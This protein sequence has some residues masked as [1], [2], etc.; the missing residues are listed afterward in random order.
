MSSSTHQILCGAC[1]RPVKTIANAK[2]NHEVTCTGCGRKDRLDKVVATAIPTLRA[3]IAELEQRLE[4]DPAQP[5]DGIETRDATIIALET[6]KENLRDEVVELRAKIAE[7]EA[8]RA[9]WVE[10]ERLKLHLSEGNIC[11]CP[12]CAVLSQAAAMIARLVERAEQ[13]ERE[14]DALKAALDKDSELLTIAYMD[15]SHRSTQAHR[16]TIKRLTAERDAAREELAKR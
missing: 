12:L 13:A 15:G 16:E 3:R 7:L 4:I 6:Y 10:V 5:Y 11:V 1:R 14:R 8:D 2:P 9:E